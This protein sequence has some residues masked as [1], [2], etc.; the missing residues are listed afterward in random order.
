M[1]STLLI[2]RFSRVLSVSLCYAGMPVPP[3]ERIL[4]SAAASL[5]LSA[6]DPRDALAIKS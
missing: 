4:S 6:A 5:R 2:S 3:T 1:P